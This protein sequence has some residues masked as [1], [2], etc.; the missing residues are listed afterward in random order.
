MREWAL[1]HGQQ[2]ANGG[3]LDWRAGVTALYRWVSS[4]GIL[5]NSFLL[6]PVLLVEASF[7]VKTP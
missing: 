1:I 4:L 3:K 7:P 5:G 6:T 2:T